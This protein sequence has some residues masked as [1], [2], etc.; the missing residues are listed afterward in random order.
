ML[1]SLRPT[2]AWQSNIEHSYIVAEQVSTC[3]SAPSRI[4]R[5]TPTAA[6]PREAE[7]RGTAAAPRPPPAQEATGDVTTHGSLSLL[8]RLSRRRR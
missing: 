8:H 2:G 7:V 1:K 4:G 3:S 5:A 6:P